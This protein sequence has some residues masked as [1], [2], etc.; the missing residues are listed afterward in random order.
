MRAIV[1]GAGIAGPV[2]A[3]ALQKAGIDSAV[4][5][6]Y[7]RPADGLG[8]EIALAPNGIAA[9]DV[10]GASAA[11]VA[12]SQPNCRQE[13]AVGPG[14]KVTLPWLADSAPFRLVRRSDLFRILHDQAVRSGIDVAYGKRLVSVREEAGSVTARFA[15]GSSATGDVLI[16]ADGVHSTVR[17]L[18]DP[19]APGPRY[20]GMLAVEGWSPVETGN[21][22][23]TMTF[24][25][26][27]KGYYLYW[28]SA[29][30][31]TWG[32]NMPSV[33]PLLIA[34][35]RAVPAAEWKRR[36]IDV[37]GGD[38]PG[39]EF[40]R[41][42]DPSRLQI[43]G[44][45]HIMPPVPHWYRG[46]MVLVGDSVHAPSNSSGQGAALAI[47]SAVEL[48]RCL[49]DLPVPAAFAAYVR[50]RRTRVE[51]I[52]RQAAR[53][54]SRKAPGPVARALMPVLMPLFLKTVMNPSRTLA[55]IL[56]SRIDW[57]APVTA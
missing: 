15:D 14:K 39:G 37:Y 27:A 42:V 3:L 22:P 1:V 46:R 47:E 48:A 13:L 33:R 32:A 7:P 55:P 12:A 11:V 35:A 25:F 20:T 41:S 6:A 23:G 5:E 17:T 21:A 57:A 54:N 16:G 24:T 10:V 26:G 2:T 56:N 50:L 30:G 19:H 51:G 29:G 28:P 44:A 31:T 53:T 40:V 34:E 43:N 38:T 52:A 36:L 8:G 18:I 45:L 4:Y 49:R 9:L